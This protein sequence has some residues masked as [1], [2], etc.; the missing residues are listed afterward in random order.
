MSHNIS[1]ATLHRHKKS[2][3][4][5]TTLQS[6]TKEDLNF[7]NENGVLSVTYGIVNECSDRSLGVH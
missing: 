5:K 1:F 2:R 4:T 3:P 6:L 7:F